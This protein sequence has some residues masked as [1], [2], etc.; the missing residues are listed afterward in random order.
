MPYYK[1]IYSKKAERDIAEFMR[2]GNKSLLQKLAA[3]LSEL[4][5]HPQTGTGKPERLK[6]DKSGLWSRRISGEHRLVYFI[7]ED[8]VQVCVISA[9][10]HY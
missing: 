10:G 9:K 1:I 5:Y 2:S 8:I 3:L 6:H 7:E 4:Q